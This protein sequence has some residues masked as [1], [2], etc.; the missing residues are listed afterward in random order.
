MKTLGFLCLAVLIASP[1]VMA[2]EE[3]DAG[4]WSGKVKVGYLATSGNTDNS[5]LNSG[6]EVGYEVG[7]WL[8]EAKAAAIY[9]DEG[10]DTTSEAYEAGWKSSIDFS[11]HD[12]LFGRLSWRKDRFSSFDSQFS[13]TVGY[14][15][16][17]IDTDRHSLNAEI[18]AGARQS[19]LQDGTSIDETVFRGGVNYRWTISDTSEFRQDL[20]VEAGD[21][22][23][24]TESVTAISARLIGG[25]ALTASYTI[26]NNSDVLADLEKKDTFTA[27][28]LEYGF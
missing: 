6:L 21:E 14:G 18:G 4:P 5:N 8:H 17:L 27:L 22:N 20:T 10:P 19:D 3:A 2:A 13:Q 26:R 9:A 11:E 24:F 25:L 28:S 1:S 15:R 12:F 23:T 16:H 7:N